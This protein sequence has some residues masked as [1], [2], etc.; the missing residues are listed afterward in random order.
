[1]KTKEQIISFL[2]DNKNYFRE[3]F[4][5]VRIGIFG[6]YSRGDNT[7]TSDID[8]LVEFEDGT[9]DLYDKKCKLKAYIKENL[10][11][12]ADICREKYIKPR[13]KASILKE[14]RYAY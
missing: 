14:A 6:S 5:I 10:C 11:L 2:I 7:T 12:D 3:N 4:N 9:I 8:L 1:M 13:F